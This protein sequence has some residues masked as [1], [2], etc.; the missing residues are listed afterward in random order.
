[1]VGHRQTLERLGVVM[2]REALESDAI[3]HARRL[4]RTGLER[5][6]LRRRADGAVVYETSREEFPTM[7]LQRADGFPTQHLRLIAVYD[8][9]LQ[10]CAP[11]C[12][13]VDVC[14]SEWQ[15]A[16]LVHLDLLR[17]LR[18]EP[19]RGTLRPLYHG[20]VT[21]D[22]RQVSSSVGSPELID[23]LLD[24][25]RDAPEVVRLVDRHGSGLDRE[26]IVALLVKGHFLCQ[27][28]TRPVEFSRAALFD[29]L[30]SPG[31]TLA[32]AW[33]R[34]SRA[35]ESIDG[36]E[37]REAGQRL[38]V[39]RSQAYRHALE[40]STRNLELSALTGFTVAYSKHA[41]TTGSIGATKVAGAVLGPVFAS[42]GLLDR[43]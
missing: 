15:P 27:A 41:A 39:L 16:F 21:F 2:Q 20:M 22:D 23:D 37:P 1:M 34:A 10:R 8:R 38:A 30:R 14:G 24:R 33:C 35:R 17:Q 7:Y 5:G 25:L 40:H 4:A 36:L 18:P 28:Q 42:L 19:H 11:G 32:E 12:I 31:W 13:Y 9:L 26:T 3:P 6:L 29:P 43:H